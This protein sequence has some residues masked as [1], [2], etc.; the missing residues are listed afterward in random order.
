M[1]NH[2]IRRHII[3]LLTIS[4]QLFLFLYPLVSQSQPGWRRADNYRPVVCDSAVRLCHEAPWVLIYEDQFEGDRLNE[5][6][7]HIYTGVPRDPQFT[8]QKAW[9]QQENIEVGNGCLKIITRREHKPRTPFVTSYSPPTYD[10]TDFDYTTGEVWSKRQ[11]RYGKY[12]ARIKIPKGWGLWPAFW[13][14]GDSHTGNE[15]DIFEYWNERNL[16]GLP[17]RSELATRQHMTVHYDFDHDGHVEQH[18]NR[19]THTDM[20]EDFHIYTLI[21]LPGYIKWL[22]DGQ[23]VYQYNRYFYN[24]PFRNPAGCLLFSGRNYLQNLLFPTPPMSVIFNTAVQ[25]GN[26]NE[27]DERTP[28]PARMEVDW[29]RYYVSAYNIRVA[30]HDIEPQYAE[31]IHYGYLTEANPADTLT[32]PAKGGTLSVAPRGE[33]ASGFTLHPDPSSG[34][35]VI[36]CNEDLVAHGEILV[37]SQ[38]G[39]LLNKFRIVDNLTAVELATPP[40]T[41]IL[42]LRNT[43]TDSLS[44][45]KIIKR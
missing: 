3:R 23:T 6:D 40:G 8:L 5:A 4:L 39:L 41:Y 21:Y 17:A 43:Q 35:I 9:H 28:L 30:V 7:W 14:Y 2:Q 33:Q 26:G 29:F 15:V 10:T 18:G 42:A 38:D 34:S 13:L 11:F 16:A 27:P 45:Y 31:G 24:S 1:N 12:E 44:S 20:S 25:C 19:F 36:S 37:F 32:I 22:V